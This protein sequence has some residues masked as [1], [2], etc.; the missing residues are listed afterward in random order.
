MMTNYIALPI[1]KFNIPDYRLDPGS[2]GESISSIYEG[3]ITTTATV[4]MWTLRQKALAAH[5][6][7]SPEDKGIIHLELKPT[8]IDDHEIVL[9]PHFDQLDMNKIYWKC[10]LHHFIEENHDNEGTDGAPELN[11]HQGS[12]LGLNVLVSS[13]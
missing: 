11:L 5:E 1:A 9:P 13:C 6:R 4:S 8:I 2:L 10:V 3:K 7:A 12:L